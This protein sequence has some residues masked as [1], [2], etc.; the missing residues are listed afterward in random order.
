MKTKFNIL[1]ALLTMATLV[2]GFT[3]C[4]EDPY[5]YVVAEGQPEVTF[6]RLPSAASADSLITGA[7]MDKFVCL[8]G[9]NLKSTKAVR[10]NDQPAILNTSLITD[11]TMLIQVPKGIPAVV[12]D[13]IYLV[14]QNGNTVTFPFK[15]LVPAPS[16]LSITNEFAAA[17]EE[18]TIFGDFF[19]DDPNVPL[20][21]IMPDGT[22]IAS[23]DFTSFSKTAI[24]FNI[25]AAADLTQTGRMYV[26]SIYGKS[27]SNFEFHDERCMILDFDGSHGGLADGN[28]WR[29]S[30]KRVE[31]PEIPALDGE[32]LVLGGLMKEAGDWNDDG[33]EYDVWTDGALAPLPTSLPK[34]AAML[35]ANSISD[36]CCKFEVYVPSTSPW[37]AGALQVIWMG[38]IYGNTPQSSETYPRGLWNP[39]Q[40]TGTY[41]T[42]KWVTVTMPLKD[43]VYNNNGKVV[44]AKID[45]TYFAGLTLFVCSG[46]VTGT[47]CTP[48]IAF[49]NFRVVPLN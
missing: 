40:G 5:K 28:G 30:L 27:R 3:A 7:M 12:T 45:E 24:T 19:L 29:H 47:E 31:A 17:D 34:F 49:D 15:V 38:D 25:P 21:V 44:D 18:V 41:F 22:E 2:L 20:T 46:G 13:S 11:N 9:K 16:V 35:K 8:V 48:K 14:G 6:V 1:F 42:D 10:F 4:Q 32:F 33:F 39:W 36:L 23:A 26:R 37:S 43:F